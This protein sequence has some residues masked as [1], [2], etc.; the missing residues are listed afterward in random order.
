MELEYL[1]FQ[2]FY[3]ESLDQQ[4]KREEEPSKTPQEEIE[5]LQFD[6]SVF[7][8]GHPKSVVAIVSGSLNSDTMICDC[9]FSPL[10][11]TFHCPK[12]KNTICQG[13]HEF[14]QKTKTFQCPWCKESP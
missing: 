7:E 9:C 1:D 5:E 8:L 14:N 13:C 4:D 10:K 3:F 12:H 2:Q 6:I 11:V